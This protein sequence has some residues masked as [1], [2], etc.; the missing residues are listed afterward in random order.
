MAVVVRRAINV[1][2]GVQPIKPIIGAPEGRQ[3]L[4]LRNTAAAR[5]FIKTPDGIRCWVLEDGGDH[6]IVSPRLEQGRNLRK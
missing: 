5:L 1:V 4:K 3:R 6:W 2:F